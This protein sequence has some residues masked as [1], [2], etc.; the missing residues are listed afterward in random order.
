V[1]ACTRLSLCGRGPATQ[2]SIRHN[3]SLNKCF[4][5][6]PRGD[7][8]RGKGA[9]WMLDP[10]STLALSSGML[11]K[12]KAGRPGDDAAGDGPAAAR[13]EL[14]PLAAVDTAAAAGGG[15]ASGKRRLSV[16]G[17]PLA[18]DLKRRKSVDGG[19]TTLMVTTLDPPMR[20]THHNGGDGGDGGEDGSVPAQQEAV[21]ASPTTIAGRPDAGTD[22][23]EAIWYP[24]PAQRLPVAV[25][26]GNGHGVPVRLPTPA[27]MAGRGIRRSASGAG[28]PDVVADLEWAPAAAAQSNDEL[29]IVNECNDNLYVDATDAQRLWGA[30]S[31]A[32]SGVNT[33]R[34]P[35]TGLP[36]LAP[37]PTPP[38]FPPPPKP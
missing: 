2:N 18:L 26:M 14:G 32:N 10:A 36:L 17:P 29:F 31:V 23:N 16:P 15:R 35:G 28:T 33:P 13:G 27:S 37:T 1:Y 19:A 3:L 38:P 9:F 20:T 34:L 5:K 30:D 24:R 22:A 7:N 4:I 21:P 25:R 6:V 11:K 8:E 12:R